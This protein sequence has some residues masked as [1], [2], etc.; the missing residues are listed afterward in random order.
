MSENKYK[1]AETLERENEVEIVK[2]LV[3][4]LNAMW[5]KGIGSFDEI[6]PES[7]AADD[8]HWW[9]LGWPRNRDGHTNDER[10]HSH[11]AI[12]D[13]RF[14]PTARID[15]VAST[16]EGKV[17][18]DDSWQ[19]RIDNDTSIPLTQTVTKSV[20][21]VRTKKSTLTTGITAE[22]SAETTASVKGGV[23]G[24]GEASVSET[25]KAV[26]GTSLGIEKDS[27][28]DDT[29][30]D[31]VSGDFT[32]PPFARLIITEQRR[33]AVTITPWT[34]R[35]VREAG[36][37]FQLY[38]WLYNASPW[39]KIDNPTF[40]SFAELVQALHGGDTRFTEMRGW[41]EKQAPRVRGAVNWL[42]QPINRYLDLQGEDRDVY[43]DNSG[44]EEPARP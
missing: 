15:G 33:R 27:G 6:H 34:A 22:V 3:I 17:R 20:Q 44:H 7:A 43:E 28:E 16:S 39:L 9:N 18:P 4:I 32:A 1:S 23:P 21:L 12:T 42:E 8:D 38:K 19:K 10:F 13:R 25:L 2:K 36:L 26:L 41:Y 14:D 24:V 31:T 37:K 30:A 35:G 29:V 5:V 40:V 11:V